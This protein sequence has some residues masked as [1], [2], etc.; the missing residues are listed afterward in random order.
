[1]ELSSPTVQIQF[2]RPVLHQ[3]TTEFVK[4]EKTAEL[5]NDPI[6]MENYLFG[7]NHQ[8]VL[9]EGVEDGQSFN[10]LQLIQSV[11]QNTGNAKLIIFRN[12][13]GMLQNFDQCHGFLPSLFIQTA[14]LLPSALDRNRTAIASP[15]GCPKEALEANNGGAMPQERVVIRRNGKRKV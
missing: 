5:T 10:P 12:D 11:T 6:K 15:L 4:S 1:M 2:V 13:H 14:V 7:G 9:A 3:L 8:G